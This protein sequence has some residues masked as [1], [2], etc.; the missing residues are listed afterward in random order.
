MAKFFDRSNLRKAVTT[1]AGFL[2]APATLTRTGV[3]KYAPPGEAPFSVLRLPEEV[4]SPESM[5]SFE[6]L[7]AV[8]DHPVTNDGVVTKQNA[9]GLQV[10]SVA[11][12]VRNGH[13]L[14]GTILITDG[15][16]IDSI[17][18]G[19]VQVSLGYFADKE[20]APPG[21]TYRDPVSG[22]DESY[23]FVQ[24]NIRGNHVAIV[25]HARAGDMARLHLDAACEVDPVDSEAKI[26]PTTNPLTS[27]MT[28]KVAQKG[29]DEMEKITV[30]GYTFDADPKLAT[31]LGKERKI[32]A[33]LIAAGETSAKALKSTVD[34]VQ[35]VC[36]SATA[37]V[38]KL[39]AEIVA[40]KDP[41]NVEAAVNA[42]VAVEKLAGEHGITADGKD[43]IAVKREVCSKLNPALKLEGKSADYV[44][45][46]FDALSAKPVTNVVTDAAEKLIV[47][48]SKV[49]PA[50]SENLQKTFN[51][52]VYGQ[53]AA[54]SK[55]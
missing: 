1:D 20:P 49:V 41:K 2:R 44:E 24:R 50:G 14:D 34:K 23:D 51:A 13:L 10:G 26:V 42:R 40:L 6:Q 43:L 28:H 8:I 15:D 54:D 7:P 30:D 36:D 3:F 11:A 31:A 39:T 37:D 12:L 25:Q 32:A 9:K 38:A 18:A 27:H 55:K 29:F 53:N 22:L 19:K 5:A 35:A 46:M 47:S 21:S 33:D 4:F 17:N 45:A 52:A 48:D 16:A